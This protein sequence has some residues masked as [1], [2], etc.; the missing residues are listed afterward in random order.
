MRY[1]KFLYLLIGLALFAVVVAETDFADAGARLMQIGWGLAVVLA[2]YFVTFGLD[3]LTWLITLRTRPV[4]PTWLVRMWKVR[5]VGEAFNM[6]VPAGGM[7][8]EPVKAVLLKQQYGIDYREGTASLFLSKTVNMI[9]LAAF[10]AAGLALMLRQGS[11]PPVYELAGG[12]G[13]AAFVSATT[14]FFVI[15]RF[16]LSSAVTGMLTRRAVTRRLAGGLENIHEVESHFIDFYSGRRARFAA[17]VAIAWLSWV[18]GVLEIYYTL[19]FLGHPV[20]FAEAWIIE[21][22]AQMVRAGAFFVPAGIGLQDGA[23]VLIS[24]AI[25]GSTELGV[26]VALVRRIREIIWIAAGF[27]LGSLFRFSRRESTDSGVSR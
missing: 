2:L 23:F 12:I 15:Q 13:L 9:G 14:I 4:S 21:A 18:I 16:R 27:A 11:L 26:A 7:G 24:A 8:G 1:V 5:L 25:T 10:L 17:T 6:T 20:S 22:M 3:S 19:Q